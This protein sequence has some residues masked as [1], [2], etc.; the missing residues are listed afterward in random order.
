[1]DQLWKDVRVSFR[2]LS[3]NPGFT[4]V[5]VITMALGI[6]SNTAVF[7]VV[8]GVLL[9]PLRYGEAD[10]LVL[11]E[12]HFPERLSTR[13]T[14]SKPEW[15]DLERDVES[16]SGVGAFGYGVSNIQNE[17]GT[18]LLWTGWISSNL[19]S[20]LEAEPVL[21]RGFAADEHKLDNYQYAILGHELWQTRYGGREDV[22]GETL[23]IDDEPHTIVGVLGPDFQ[24]P[25]DFQW[26]GRTP[27][28]LPLMDPREG[29]SRTSRNV[30]LV[31]R[32]QPGEGIERIRAQVATVGRQMH[33]QFPENYPEDEHS[34][35]VRSLREATVGTLR[36][37]LLLG[38]VAVAF[39]LLLAC[40]N[41]VNLLLARALA[42]QREIAMQLALGA[43]RGGLLRQLAVESTLFT[44][45][46][47]ALGVLL[48]HWGTRV[49]VAATPGN[50]PRL[51]EVAVDGRVLLFTL[52]LSIVVG[53]VI[54]LV[55]A[56]NTGRMDLPLALRQGSG[57]AGWGSRQQRFRRILLVAQ[58]AFALLLLIGAGLVLRTFQNLRQVDLG[59]D[60]E[61][62]VAMGVRL[63]PSNYP[64][65]QQVRTF[66]TDAVERFR[67]LPGIDG[68][69][70]V[71]ALPLL[72]PPARQAYLI[73]GRVI[74]DPDELPTAV[75][76]AV[77]PGYL[78]TMRVPLREGRTFTAEDR[79]GSLETV[80]VNET[81]A[82][83]QWPDGALGQRLKLADPK[84]PEREFVWRTV[85]GVVGD[86]RN[87]GLEPPPE[88]EIYVPH[89]QGDF[90][91]TWLGRGMYLTVRT[92]MEPNQLDR[93]LRKEM[94]VLDPSI[95]LG[96]LHFMRE[97]LGKSIAQPRF[98]TFILSIFGALALLL[99][100]VGIYGV[101]AYSARQRVQEIGIRM[102][103]GAQRGGIFRLVV[104]EGLI[105]ALLGIGLGLMA[106]FWAT[107][108]LAGMLFGV[109]TSD[110]LTF[111]AGSVI[112]VVVAVLASFVPAL[113]ATRVDPI[114]ILRAD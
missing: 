102:A 8:D 94:Q 97:I 29:D 107:R 61:N 89:Q 56:L 66:F 14:F 58:V 20:V 71:A 99:A 4:L 62:I 54:G 44:L 13:T 76:Q 85:V 47:G 49:L 60:A 90:A 86:V 79:A 19:L 74:N 51:E 24:L 36:P 110:P 65:A 12:N 73:E 50:V 105:L 11:L 17:E 5:A 9:Q 27:L 98:T 68:V 32:R 7:S 40:V 95:P 3:K 67:N 70:A 38:L 2:R 45:V 82:N 21:G 6:G 96:Q 1:M 18:R 88:P 104:G 23:R 25:L 57:G 34:I 106:A 64:D 113:R 100:A 101:I 111:I 35:A 15:V 92:A 22:L 77:T 41:L 87:E 16:L 37:A 59:F 109:T 114:R 69:G 52:L 55:P 91:S 103:L 33:Q 46:G 63:P 72:A 93:L 84:D 80:L 108:L 31:A 26:Q 39:V 53:V 10:Q 78:E 75:L 42:R 30:Q 28:F 112:L 48:A 43:G 83:R 81:L